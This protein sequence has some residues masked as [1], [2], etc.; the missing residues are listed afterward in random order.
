MHGHSS[1]PN[2][3]IIES[4]FNVNSLSKMMVF[5]AIIITPMIIVIKIFETIRAPLPDSIEQR[6]PA[7]GLT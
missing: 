6:D 2:D 3:I 5:D 1:V 7:S 4:E